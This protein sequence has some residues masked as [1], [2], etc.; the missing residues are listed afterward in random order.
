MQRLRDI[1]YLDAAVP[2]PVRLWRRSAHR[3]PVGYRN[4]DVVDLTFTVTEGPRTYLEELRVEGNRDRATAAGV[5]IDQVRQALYSA[6]GARRIP[7]RPK[8]FCTRRARAG[9]RS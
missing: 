2:N 4:P 6:F 1:G 9:W 3:G 5:S 7:V 8:P